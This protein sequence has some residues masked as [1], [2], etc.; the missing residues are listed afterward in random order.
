M[1]T[2][3][4]FVAELTPAVN[5]AEAERRLG[6]FAASSSWGDPAVLPQGAPQEFRFVMGASNR[7]EAIARLTEHL[8]VPVRLGA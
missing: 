4:T 1:L 6:A 7:E 5:R 2:T 8:G 3:F